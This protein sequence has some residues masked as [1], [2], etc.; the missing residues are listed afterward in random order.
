MKEILRARE[1]IGK[2]FEGGV[3]QCGSSFSLSPG[4]GR[5]VCGVVEV[6]VGGGLELEEFAT[7]GG[8]VDCEGAARGWAVGEGS[9]EEGVVWGELGCWCWRGGL[10]GG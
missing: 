1:R 8:D 5:G 6:R 10:G 9:R 4:R 7:E 2:G 3:D